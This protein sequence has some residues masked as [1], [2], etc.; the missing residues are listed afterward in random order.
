MVHGCTRKIVCQHIFGLDQVYG[1]FHVFF[2]AQPEEGAEK[3]VAVEA[4]IAL[5]KEVMSKHLAAK[6]VAAAG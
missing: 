3:S 1:K 6:E 2:V 4:R 5:L